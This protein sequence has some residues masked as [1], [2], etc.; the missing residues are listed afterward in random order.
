MRDFG[1]ILLSK[2]KKMSFVNLEKVQEDAINKKYGICAAE[3]WDLFSTK[4][5]IDAAIEVRSP[6]ILIINTSVVKKFGIKTIVSLVKV[7]AESTNVPVVL[8]LDECLESELIFKCIKEGFP[9]VMFDGAELGLDLEE[10]IKQTR[11]IVKY[12]HFMGVTVEASLGKMP[13][14]KDGYTDNLSKLMV[15]T[16]PEEAKEFCFKTKIDSLAPSFGNYHEC[17][18]EKW[19]EPDFELV[20]KIFDI[21]GGVPISGH[22]CTGISD[23]QVSK[24][25]KSGIVKFNI[26]TLFQVYFRESIKKYIDKY[27]GYPAALNICNDAMIDLKEYLKEKMIKVFNSAYKV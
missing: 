14:T 25:I 2:G 18:K 5:F 7:Y 23:K 4:A 22:G 19:P 8:H 3:I 13:L 26:G 10:N 16:V 24:A 17:Y 21:T 15:K 20:R 9:S 11:E 27:E 1:N 6:I 12:A